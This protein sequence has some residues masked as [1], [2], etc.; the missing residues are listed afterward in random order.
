MIYDIIIVGAGISSLYTAYKLIQQNPKLKILILEK[1]DYIGGRIKTGYHKIENHMYQFEEGAGRFND[2]HK[3]LLKLIKELNL[4]KYIQKINAKI[5]FKPSTK[6]NKKFINESPFKYIDK[7][8]KASK[9]RSKRYLQ[10]FV[11]IEYA[12]KVL[13]SNQIKFILNSFGYYKQLVKMNA[14]NAIKLFSK[15]MNTDL[16]FYGLKCGLSKI[17]KK[18]TDYLKDKSKSCKILLNKNVKNI[19]YDI[20]K[21]IFTLYTNDDN[22]TS[23]QSKKCILA[24]PKPDLLKFKILNEVEPILKSIGTKSLCRIYSIFKKDDIWFKDITKTTNNNSRYIIPIDKEY[25]LIMISYSD[26]KFAHYWKRLKEESESKFIHQLKENIYKTFHIKIK[27]PIYTK[28]CYWEL[29]TGFWLKDKDSTILSKKILKPY[30]NI[31]LYICGENYSESQ[32][33][34]EGALETSE[35]M[36]KKINQKDR[37]ESHSK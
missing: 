12:K 31:P 8:I 29:G 32:G 37:K 15:G 16:Q 18:L 9:K 36:I 17:T 3:L 21:S 4:A 23:Y 27:S 20:E 34:M 26:S 2:N 14:Y 6:Y 35:K 1:N 11:F 30:N 10:R 33:W 13:P 28:F 5:T 25:G 7:V 24:I 19:M 22:N